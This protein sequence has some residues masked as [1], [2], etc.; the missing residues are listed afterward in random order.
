MQLFS[1]IQWWSKRW[2]HLLQSPTNGDNILIYPSRCNTLLRCNKSLT[3]VFGAR[4]F[5]ELASRTGDSWVKQ[6]LVIRI[7]KQLS[8]NF[9]LCHC[10]CQMRWRFQ[11]KYSSKNTKHNLA[12]QGVGWEVVSD[13]LYSVAI[14]H[15]LKWPTLLS[16]NSS[17]CLKI[18]VPR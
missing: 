17:K 8:S 2:T 15:Q 12:L 10:S 3:A 11:N 18:Q 9:L 4:R 7:D 16:V 5:Q 13:I 14:K 1:Q 6:P